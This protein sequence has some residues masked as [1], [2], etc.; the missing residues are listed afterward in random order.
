MRSPSSG[1]V[2]CWCPALAALVSILRVR[3]DSAHLPFVAHVFAE[4]KDTCA[5]VVEVDPSN[6]VRVL[7]WSVPDQSPSKVSSR[8]GRRSI[9]LAALVFGLL[10]DGVGVF[11]GGPL[12]TLT[13]SLR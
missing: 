12:F 13:L 2:G 10:A 11:L 1:L 3:G 4:I 8:F 5:L 7:R 6:G 9:V